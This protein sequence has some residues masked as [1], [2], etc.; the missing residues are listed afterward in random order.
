MPNARMRIPLFLC[1]AL[2]LALVGCATDSRERKAGSPIDDD[3]MAGIGATAFDQLKL[4]GNLSADYD[5]QSFVRCV[6]DNLIAELPAEHQEVRWE[7][8][9]FEDPG[10]DAYALPGGKLGVHRDV[11]PMVDDEA[12]LAALIAHELAHLGQRHSAQRLASE[13]STESAVAAVQ[14]FRGDQSPPQTRSAF[15]LLGLGNRVRMPRPYSR[16]HEVEADNAALALMA[17]AG[18]PPTASPELWQRLAEQQGP[19]SWLITHPDPGHHVEVLDDGLEAAVIEF[20]Q[21]RAKGRQ[22]RCR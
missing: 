13:F 17:R 19:I 10:A 2:T 4:K 11:L 9:V 18:Y 5:A 3:A 21:A 22:P 6:A 15:A 20:D 16:V 1:C 12:Q 8:L 7:I 14:T